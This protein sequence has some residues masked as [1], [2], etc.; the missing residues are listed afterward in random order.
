MG[1][2]FHYYLLE[3]T[4]GRRARGGDEGKVLPRLPLPGVCIERKVLFISTCGESGRRD[5]GWER[6]AARGSSGDQTAR[7][8]SMLL[9]PGRVLMWRES[10]LKP[11]ASL[12]A[13]GVS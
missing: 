6:A 11:W 4:K 5:R 3:L 10:S 2:G 12:S 7:D 13:S 1:L 9:L 8:S